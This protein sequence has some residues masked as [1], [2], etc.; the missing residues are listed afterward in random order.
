MTRRLA[1]ISLCL[2]VG[3]VAVGG[4]YWLFL[5]TPE[6]SGLMLIASALL[7]LLIVIV[8]GLVLNTAILRALGMRLR[9]GLRPAARGVAWF[10]IAAVVVLLG[11]MAVLRGD[12]WIAAHSG[13][14]SA[15]F[16][17]QFD[18]ADISALFRAAAWVSIWIRWVILP[19]AAIAALASVL[20]N[21]ARGLWSTRWLPRVFHWRALPLST[22]LFVLL[23]ALPWQ[24]TGWRPK[25]PPTWVELAVAVARLGAIAILITIG[26]SLIIDSTARAVSTR[27]SRG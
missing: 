4:L 24:A 1:V 8:A 5:N 17:A 23:V 25:L 2:G 9:A 3:A 13:E 20:S 10:V 11:W 6:S 27:G 14:I 22:V 21:G 16:I 19:V 15:W 26:W 12:A 7:V 18:W